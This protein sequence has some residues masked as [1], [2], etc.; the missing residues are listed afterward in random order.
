[1]RP[2]RLLL[3]L[4]L[5]TALPILAG[6]IA[7]STRAEAWLAG[8]VQSQVQ[9]LLAPGWTVSR[10]ELAWDWGGG[11][12]LDGVV[13]S[14]PSGRAAVS[15]RHLG[16]V[17]VLD[18]APW[19]GV[20][21]RRLIADGVEV[22]LASDADGVLDLLRAFGGPFPEDPDAEP[23][24]GLPIGVQLDDVELRD[25]AVRMT[26]PDEAGVVQTTLAMDLMSVRAG[27]V[28]EK[29]VPGVKVTDLD[30]WAV[31][32]LPVSAPLRLTGSVGWLDDAATFD[33]VRAEVL[34]SAISVAGGVT[35]LGEALM[36]SAE[37]GTDPLD[38]ATLETLFGAPVAGMLGARLKVEGPLHGLAITGVV[39]GVNGTPGAVDLQVG[40]VVCVPDGLAH[41]IDLCAQ[42]GV[43]MA[44][45]ADA[46]LRWK[47]DL[48][49]A[50]LALERILPVVGG[51]LVL[52][53]H[54]VG[55]GHGTSWPEELAIDDLVWSGQELDAYGVRV[56]SFSLGAS[57]VGGQLELHDADL[58]GVAGTV[59][60]GGTIDL[61]EGDLDLRV[62]GE[63]LPYL[64][65]D[66]GVTQLGGQGSYQATVRGNV[67]AEGTPID[68]VGKVGMA[69]LLWDQDVRLDS[70]AGPLFVKVRNGDV[71]VKGDLFAQELDA[72][73]FTMPALSVPDAAVTVRD[74]DVAVSGTI[75]GPLMQYGDLVRIE[76]PTVVLKIRQPS[77]GELELDAD[78]Q[79]GP[80]DLVGLLGTHG[81]GHLSM[82]GSKL[83]ADV[84][85]RWEEAPFLVA[86]GLTY[87]LDSRWV[88]LQSLD[89]EP[90]ARQ[91]WVLDAP[92]SLR[93]VDGGIT[94]ADVRISSSFGSLTV[95][96][97]LAT[98]GPLEGEVHAKGVDLEAL[99]EMFPDLL[100]GLDGQVDLD[101]VASGTAGHPEIDVKVAA[102]RLFWED[103]FRYLDVQG[104]AGVHNDRL[105]ADLG[106]K[107]GGVDW[108]NL[109][110]E[111]P[112]NANL[113]A[114]S[115]RTDLPAELRVSLA[116]GSLDRF[117]HAVPGLDVPEGSASALV[118]LSGPLRDP[119]LD[120]D[121]VAEL[122]LPDVQGPVRV[123]ADITRDAGALVVHLDAYEGFRPIAEVD[124][125]A[126][127][128]VGAIVD[129]LLGSG[130][131]PDFA[132]LSLYADA[133]DVQARLRDVSIPMIR[134]LTGVTADLHGHVGGT[135]A[136]TGSPRKPS[137]SADL[138]ATAEAG[139]TPLPVSLTLEPTGDGYAVDM[140]LGDPE[141]PW[142]RITGVVPM[143][144]DTS[145]DWTTWGTGALA[146]TASGSGLPLSVIS[147]I[148]PALEVTAGELVVDGT[149]S[150]DV[151]APA[152]DLVLTLKGLEG[153]Y[154]P[155]G[156]A[157]R[158]G[159]G[160]VR[161]ARRPDG[162][163]VLQVVSLSAETRPLSG[164]LGQVSQGG[165]SEVR[166]TGS[167]A[168]DGSVPTDVSGR[169][170][171][172]GAWLS[173][174]P[175]RTLRATGALDLAG[176]WPAVTLRGR[177]DVDQGEFRLN[178]GDLLQDRTSVLDPA[179]A[180]HREGSV[181]ERAVRAETP[182]WMKDLV[183]SLNVGLGRNTR[184]DLKV[185]VFEDLGALGEQV[186]RA[187]IDARV[188]GDVQ[189]SMRDG[190]LS[191][192]GDVETLGGRVKVLQGE[193]MLSE[194]S[195]VSFLGRDY[196][197]PALDISGAMRVTG[198]EVR[199]ALS[200]TAL[201][202]TFSFSSDDFGSDA[203][204]L[205][206]L[207]TGK[208]PDDLSAS[209]GEAALQ[210]LG[211][212]LVSGVLGG[213]NL[214][215]VGVEPDGTVRFGLPLYRTL[216]LETTYRPT[217]G[218]QENTITV[219]AEWSILPRLLL[220]AS[221][222]D[223]QV[224][225][226]LNWELRF[227]GLCDDLRNRFDVPAPE[228]RALASC[229]AVRAAK[230]APPVV[231]EAL[232]SDSTDPMPPGGGAD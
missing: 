34:G 23:W 215:S 44:V 149:I 31:S 35:G 68:V 159:E 64:L 169:V 208:A 92:L 102:R 6:L 105:V 139:D 106:T 112:V 126:E 124:G 22:R 7:T 86:S 51:P 171:L 36:V 148:D 197:N 185:P 128:R 104:T 211:N 97:R 11:L 200:G 229:R 84:D 82:R 194:G 81:T 121:A 174:T 100:V 79:V 213:A 125:E 219:E 134:Q 141:A 78:L 107:V 29:S 135:L 66:F 230:R 168:L 24:G 129:W 111:L 116:P 146:L 73:G 216:Y 173:A 33:T 61:I 137:V 8:F 164:T 52:Q 14:D 89:F 172:E 42:E 201:D 160:S 16:A 108:L 96:G 118:E 53:G 175:E 140:V 19:S 98:Q 62:R 217:A 123:E 48:Q 21:V 85:L 30:A 18:R 65:E 203:A 202:P 182:A 225:G 150:G 227:S 117:F 176:T 27:V 83:E 204:I 10:P 32:R 195:R 177:M 143:S 183:V 188:G 130:P 75:F 56:R 49:I 133:L 103:R 147:A 50:D 145:T 187:Q 231:E 181:G 70:V 206:I 144:I 90:S 39:S 138:T 55:R 223:R 179:I 25:V 156:L 184:L 13:L 91:K 220:D 43:E 190:A 232:K 228:G 63:I 26:S 151:T 132:D 122:L 163:L 94:D 5:L 12:R 222:G 54:A 45:S 178:T 72:Y 60:G 136:V 17:W 1:M 153:R 28:L 209:Q 166:I 15:V 41:A 113:A 57:L 192:V 131:E 38:M 20:H 46:P 157:L 120:L 186:T 161:S 47:A 69:P 59:L 87:D 115:L 198:G 167:V 162:T 210:A 155:L 170:E 110:G 221:Y 77:E 199:L 180:V 165:P 37:V 71:E 101:M 76:E 158:R 99:A 119:R 88:T 196:A 93:L 114:P 95:Q 226:S 3:A 2:R 4:T 224:D 9:G 109:V 154:R 152:P 205:T 189:V 142:T 74:G 191:L 193:F 67:L 218:L 127:T 214:G 80:Q 58:L 207:L 212:V 40:T